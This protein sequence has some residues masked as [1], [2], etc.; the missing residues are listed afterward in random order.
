V[1]AKQQKQNNHTKQTTTTVA[2]LAQAILA[3]VAI[4]AQ[5]YTLVLCPSTSPVGGLSP[6]VH[7]LA[8]MRR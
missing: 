4:L 2:I 6:F 5:M 3:Q 1:C 8:T 7:G